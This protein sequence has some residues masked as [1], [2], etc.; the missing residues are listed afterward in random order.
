[1]NVINAKLDIIFK[2]LFTSDKTVLMAFIGD[3]LDIPQGK[4][5]NLEVLNP[6]LLPETSDGKQG[7]LDIKMQVDNKIV[8][9][10]IQVQMQSDYKERA[11]YYWSKMFS[12]ELK[13]GEHYA[14]LKQTISINILNFNLFDCEEPYSTFKLLETDRHEL[15]TDKCAI[16]FF[17]L[18]KVNKS[19]DKADRKK[20]WLQLI[21]AET[22]E[23]LAMIKETGVSEINKAI[24]IMHEMSED[25]KIREMARL[26]EKWILDENS[27]REFFRRQGLEEGRAEG[28]AEGKKEERTEGIKVLVDSLRAFA[29]PDEDIVGKLIE[30]YQLTKDEADVFIKQN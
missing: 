26:R 8:N 14:E 16:L 13:K 7:Q 28:R 5:Q 25:E 6:E 1:M 22:E 4:I 2:K 29:I 30:K 27:N 3:L 18:K 17:E 23:D 15:M 9:V 19:I 20:L 24:V 12:N 21:N 10:E 11:L